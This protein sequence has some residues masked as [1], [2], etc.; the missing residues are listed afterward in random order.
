M[1]NL[2]LIFLDSFSKCAKL[3]LK[4]DGITQDINHK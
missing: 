3:H 1:Y 4:K 2:S